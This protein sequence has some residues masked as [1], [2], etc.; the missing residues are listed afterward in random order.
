VIDAENRGMPIHVLRANTISQIE[1]SLAGIF[2]ISAEA[3][4]HSLDDVAAQTQ[5]AIDAVMN[6]SRWVDMPPASAPVRRMQHELARAANLV[7]HSYGKEPNRRVRI[8]RE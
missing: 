4:L 5:T 3:P 2:N 8:F 1:Q 7:S 6:G